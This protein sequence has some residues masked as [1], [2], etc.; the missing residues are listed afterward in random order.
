[1]DRTSRVHT[2]FSL[3]S[4]QKE[5]KKAEE[6]DE[7]E[8]T[9]HF[10]ILCPVDDSRIKSFSEADNQEWLVERLPFRAAKQ[11]KHIFYRRY[12]RWA[13]KWLPRIFLTG[14][15]LCNLGFFFPDYSFVLSNTGFLMTVP[16][17]VLFVMRM[18]PYFLALLVRYSFDFV[19]IT[20]VNAIL[21]LFFILVFEKRNLDFRVSGLLVAWIGI[22]IT[23]SYDAWNKADRK[24]A[25]G[26]LIAG[27][28]T[29]LSMGILMQL[30]IGFGLQDIEFSVLK[31][32]Y[33]LF[34]IIPN[35]LYT[36]T[37]FYAKSLFNILRLHT[38]R[39][40]KEEE[41][42]KQEEE[43]KKKQTNEKNEKQH[44]EE[45]DGK[46]ML[47]TI[48]IRLPL[49][50]RSVDEDYREPRQSRHQDGRGGAG[51]GGEGE[52]ETECSTQSSPATP[53]TR[54]TKTW[55]MSS[56][57][58]KYRQDGE[59]LIITTRETEGKKKDSLLF[60]MASLLL[61]T[62]ILGSS[63]LLFR[64]REEEEEEE[65]RK[66]KGEILAL[67]LIVVL[68]LVGAMVAL[69]NLLTGKLVRRILLSFDAFYLSIQ[70]SAVAAVLLIIIF[71]SSSASP[72]EECRWIGVLALWIVFHLSLFM[73][74]I[75]LLSKQ[76]KLRRIC[77]GMFWASLLAAEIFLWHAVHNGELACTLSAKT[78][79]P[80]PP[81]FQSLRQSSSSEDGKT[82]IF[83]LNLFELL[84]WR[85]VW[86][87][88][89][90]LRVLWRVLVHPQQLVFIYTSFYYSVTK[91]EEGIV[92]PASVDQSPA[93]VG[94]LRVGE[95]QESVKKAVEMM[96]SRKSTGLPS[97]K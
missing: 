20:V 15:V 40:R 29:F 25:V 61:V 22:Q 57:R 52:T 70:I 21:F 91:T 39:M 46:L 90:S 60:A 23:I 73:D 37:F 19:F 92:S 33:S 3:H 97:S 93:A 6:E 81:V 35:L 53:R 94:V 63:F 59:E 32:R 83:A 56:K 44:A 76:P 34:G 87:I 49:C 77:S 51:A 67:V 64:R 68:T 84:G 5:K 50:L 71:S 13:S 18:R 26:S 38:A 14:L 12:E 45:D 65:Q 85:I 54:S 9:T 62:C 89:P 10:W 48:S 58:R 27:I 75:V 42:K 24:E 41:S 95:R 36:V 2:E 11:L 88:I 4:K 1:M 43:K 31:I 8:E 79:F 16:T 74:A 96:M 66:E 30:G 78:H 47:S 82:E 55:M 86:L 72:F 17:N 7:D 28:L 80:L 69:R